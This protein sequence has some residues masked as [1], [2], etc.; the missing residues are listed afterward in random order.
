LIGSFPPVNHQIAKV[1]S[2]PEG[3]GMQLTDLDPTARSLLERRHH[4]TPDCSLKRIGGDIPAEQAEDKDSEN[5][6]EAQ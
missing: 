6:E 5:A 1:Y 3:S 2:Q 4:P